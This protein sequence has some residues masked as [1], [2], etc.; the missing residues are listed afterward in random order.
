MEQTHDIKGILFNFSG[1]ID[2]EGC[3]WF[4]LIWR[5]YR[6][7]GI[8]VSKSDYL[9]AHEYAEAQISE[10]NLIEP[11]F[12]L[13]QML[14][15]KLSLQIKYLIDKGLLSD[16]V[17]T[18]KYPQQLATLCYNR[19]IM[20]VRQNELILE[21]LVKQYRLG[22]VAQS[23]GNLP[24][25][26]V[27]FGLTPYFTDVI[28]SSAVN[29]NKP[30]Q[31]IFKLS[32]DALHIAPEETLCVSNS[33]NND[34]LPAQ[35]IGCQTAWLNLRPVPPAKRVSNYHITSLTDLNALLYSKSNT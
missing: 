35:G 33:L 17:C 22:I 19:A 34:L 7:T 30:D 25:M 23:Y 27:D 11:G 2:T 13:Y 9:C 32:V 5:K 20:H 24:A 21:Q 31:A 28:E 14:Y 16:N 10:C 4:D 18:R 1:T 8:P 15:I 12:N 3:E 29:L 6:E 26:L